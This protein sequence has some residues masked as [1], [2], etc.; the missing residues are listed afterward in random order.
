MPKDFQR[1][2]VIFAGIVVDAARCVKSRTLRWV[3]EPPDNGRGRY[4]Q[5]LVMAEPK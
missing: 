3:P 5:I 4:A 1:E 2:W